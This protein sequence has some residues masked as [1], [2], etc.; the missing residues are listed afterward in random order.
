MAA[1]ATAH[2]ISEPDGYHAHLYAVSVG[3]DM[4]PVTI[5]LNLHDWMDEHRQAHPNARD[6]YAYR[7]LGLAGI[8]PLGGFDTVE[9]AWT[10]LNAPASV[11]A[12]AC[13]SEKG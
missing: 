10:A 6:V 4:R 1:E 13:E 2:C 3:D 5:E 11:P 12:V 7:R 9:E 8:E